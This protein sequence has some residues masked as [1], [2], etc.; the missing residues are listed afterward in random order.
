[1]RVIQ[2][3]QRVEGGN[4]HLG[5][6]VVTGQMDRD[7]R[8]LGALRLSQRLRGAQPARP[9]GLGELEAIGQ[10]DAEDGQL[11][12]QQYCQHGPVKGFQIEVERHANRPHEQRTC[13]LDQ[14]GEKQ[15]SQPL[16]APEMHGEPEHRQGRERH[17]DQRFVE[18]LRVFLDGAFQW[19]FGF[20]TGVEHAP[21]RFHTPCAGLFPGLIEGFHHVV[22][23]VLAFGQRKP[24]AQ[25]R[26]L[27]GD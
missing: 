6:F 27:I 1:M 3:G 2:Q 15:F 10:Q 8:P 12:G 23:D 21:V 26:R 14:A 18:P 9:E 19:V 7:K 5:R 22:V 16:E 20:A 4:H 25:K 17:R 24:T 13:G 11:R